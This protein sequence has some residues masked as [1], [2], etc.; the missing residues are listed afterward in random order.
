MAVF[1]ALAYVYYHYDIIS[2]SFLNILGFYPERILIGSV[3]I[4]AKIAVASSN[5]FC[6][7]YT[8]LHL[9]FM[10]PEIIRDK[11]A[12]QDRKQLLLVISAFFYALRVWMLY[13]FTS[14]TG[15]PTAM[16]FFPSLTIVAISMMLIRHSTTS[17]ELRKP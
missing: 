13:L 17:G 1:I 7:L 10:K 12:R 3:P 15:I 6:I 9:L 4:Y 14:E 5:I 2:E 8:V 16:M 11:Y